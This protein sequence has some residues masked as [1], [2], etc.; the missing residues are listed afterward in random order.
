MWRE[1]A[2]TFGMLGTPLD[3]VPGRAAL[4]RVNTYEITTAQREIV[5]VLFDKIIEITK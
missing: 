3:A 5:R 2:K 1:V 4:E